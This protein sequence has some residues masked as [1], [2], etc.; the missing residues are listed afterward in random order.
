[1]KLNKIKFIALGLIILVAVAGC[2]PT[3]TGMNTRNRLS[4][5]TRIRNNG[6]DNGWN[7]G[8]N[9]N[10]RLNT[11]LSGTN[12]GD[13]F[14]N[15]NMDNLNGLNNTNLNNGMTRRNNN[16]TTSLGNLSTT[17]NNLAR[18]IAA[19]PEVEDAS[20]VLTN[21]TAIVGCNLRGNTQ[22]TMTTALR[23]KI[24]NIVRSSN[25][26]IDRVSITSDPDLFTR[27]RNMSTDIRNGGVM[28][29]IEN[30]IEDLIRRITPNTNIN[31]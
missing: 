25:R 23:Q 30:D 7:T 15:R 2:A 16:F 19:L 14:D 26:N 20:V 17:A 5:Q 27:I 24:E 11:N 29:T 18:R 9:T 3:D 21:D 31:R 13:N 28:N 8:W 4:T 12:I 1:M 6:F 22:G 10:N